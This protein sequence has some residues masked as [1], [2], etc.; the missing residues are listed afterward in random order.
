MDELKIN[1]AIAE[2]T[3]AIGSDCLLEYPSDEALKTALDVLH[4]VLNRRACGERDGEMKICELKINHY[5]NRQK[6]TSILA[7]AGYK[8]SVEERDGKH[9]PQKDRFVIVE[10]QEATHDQ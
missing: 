9:Y 4:A 7:E 1:Q 8:V 5:E 3:S 10:E 6:I 2:I